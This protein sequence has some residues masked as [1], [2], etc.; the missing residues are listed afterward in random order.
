M[1]KLITLFLVF[2]L[3]SVTLAQEITLKDHMKQIGLEFRT[4]GMGVSQGVIS[5]EQMLAAENIEAIVLQASQLL[6]ETATTEEKVTLY[7]QLMSELLDAS[8]ALQEEIGIVLN[9]EQ[10]PQDLQ[11]VIA[12]MQVMIEI[13]NQG[14]SEF[15]L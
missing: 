2:G 8:V 3:Q 12:V 1:K 10:N 4:L 7:G 5:Q 9:G 14:H 13:R 15:K 6:P 11:A